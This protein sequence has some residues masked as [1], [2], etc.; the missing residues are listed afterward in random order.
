MF[1]SLLQRGSSGELLPGRFL[2]RHSCLC[3]RALVGCTA[4][5]TCNPTIQP[6]RRSGYPAEQRCPRSLVGCSGAQALRTFTGAAHA[7]NEHG[8]EPV[9]QR[10]DAMCKRRVVTT[11]L[12]QGSMCSQTSEHPG[13]MAQLVQSAIDLLDGMIADGPTDAG[14]GASAL[15]HCSVSCPLAELEHPYL[16]QVVQ[17][18]F[19][20]PVLSPA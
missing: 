4:A 9:V 19:C 20:L 1:K 14:K 17:H 5:R 7:Q 2:L 13:S 8:L 6:C 12:F 18:A 3:L 16:H 15:C 10:V 11:C